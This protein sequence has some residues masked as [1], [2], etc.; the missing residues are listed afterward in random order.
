MTDETNTQ[1]PE[2]EVIDVLPPDGIPHKA[3]LYDVK[4]P[5]QESVMVTVIARSSTDAREG[6]KQNCPEESII[7]YKGISTVIMQF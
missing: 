7:L 5:N 2:L 6:L 1:K 3:Y 4:A